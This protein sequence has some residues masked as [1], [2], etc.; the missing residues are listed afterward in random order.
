MT[1]DAIV[2]FTI[3]S[4]VTVNDDDIGKFSN[5]N[6][7]ILARN[8]FLYLRSIYKLQSG[9][10]TFKD[11]LRP[12]IIAGTHA[13]ISS[14]PYL[15]SLQLHDR[16]ICGGTI[17]SE[18]IILTAAH[19]TTQEGPMRVEAGNS[20]LT[21]GKDRPYVVEIIR[22]EMF[23]LS[24]QLEYD[25]ALLKI[26]TDIVLNGD[27]KDRVILFDQ[28]DIA[29]EGD[30]AIAV[31]WGRIFQKDVFD[32]NEIPNGTYI[33]TEPV[34]VT[35]TLKN[36]QKVVLGAI[37][38]MVESDYLNKAILRVV[39]STKC[40][41]TW[42]FRGEICAYG[43][44]QN[45]CDGDSGGPLLIGDRQAG[46]TFMRSTESCVFKTWGSAFTGV[47]PYRDWIDKTTKKLLT[48]ED[49]LVATKNL[50]ERP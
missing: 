47:A 43:Y 19:C 7:V 42:S 6:I 26:D 48:P 50:I 38:A 1:H 22:H 36:G 13:N 3:C 27:N 29:E 34:N 5:C 44:K 33:E 4:V 46:I 17:I 20:V 11:L 49:N 30:S 23:N 15:V 2:G 18:R 14:Y 45:A 40:S 31:G 16:H 25:I 9:I 37:R 39:P 28:N 24:K 12:R 41:T 21:Y 32:H 35:K 8:A 10:S